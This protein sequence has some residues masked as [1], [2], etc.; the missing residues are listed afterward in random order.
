MTCPFLHCS[1]LGSILHVPLV[2]WCCAG[3]HDT[4]NVLIPP[5]M[6][7]RALLASGVKETS[8]AANSGPSDT[9]AVSLPVLMSQ[10]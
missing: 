3:S 9:V 7:T 4:A 2:Y 8:P 10:V 5:S 1:N 6:I